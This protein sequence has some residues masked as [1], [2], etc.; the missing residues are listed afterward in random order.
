MATLNEQL[1]ELQTAR[2]NIKT[3][4][5]GK[6]Q[7]VTKDIRTYAEAINN[8]VSGEGSG[9]DTS[10]ATATAEDIILNKTAYVNGEKVTGTLT[11]MNNQDKI[12]TENGV[13]T[14]DEGYTGLG[15]V[16]VNV[17]NISND[18]D[19]PLAITGIDGSVQI[20]SSTKITLIDD[21]TALITVTSTD[22]INLEQVETPLEYV[23]SGLV[24]LYDAIENSNNGH[25]S[26]ASTWL[27]TVTKSN[28][29]VI[30]KDSNYSY[31]W[32]DN[33]L[34]YSS[35]HEFYLQSSNSYTLSDCTIEFCG[36]VKEN[37][38]NGCVINVG[39]Q[40][41]LKQYKDNAIVIACGSTTKS[42][43]NIDLTN[44]QTLAFVRDSEKISLYINGELI[45]S[46][47]V[48]SSSISGVLRINHWNDYS[49]TYMKIHGI[50]VYN[51]ALSAEE[52][53][54]NNLVDKELYQF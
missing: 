4:I 48:A 32:T 14:A 47:S 23:Q 24:S 28:Y 37:Q 34:D 22:S 35:Q 27:D 40:M 9:I 2:D 49:R 15:S 13:Y 29:F 20:T 26:S 17:E 16:T 36:L 42:V 43:P 33:A 30:N 21:N 44:V 41:G 46:M 25:N 39:N 5:E 1:T 54:N 31:N 50:R 10:D 11:P 53:Y 3:A 19:L 7:T 6:G 12:I 45:D 51:K 38:N 8:I 18:S 52:L